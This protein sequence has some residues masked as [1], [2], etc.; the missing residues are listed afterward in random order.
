MSV[1]ITQETLVTPLLK[2]YTYTYISV[3]VQFQLLND[4]VSVLLLYE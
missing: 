1:K 3:P 4:I 2:Y